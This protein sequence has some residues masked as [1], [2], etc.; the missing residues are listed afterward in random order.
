M[1]SNRIERDSE[2]DKSDY[3][4]MGPES[5]SSTSLSALY[6][7][8][9]RTRDSEIRSGIQVLERGMGN[10]LPSIKLEDSK[11]T[12]APKVEEPRVRIDEPKVEGP[13]QE[14]QKPFH[15]GRRALEV[16]FASPEVQK[17][18]DGNGSFT[19]EAIA[20]V[21]AEAAANGNNETRDLAAFVNRHFEPLSRMDDDDAITFDPVISAADIKQLPIYEEGIRGGYFYRRQDPRIGNKDLLEAAAYGATIGTAVQGVALA[22]GPGS[23][24]VGVVAAMPTTLF[25]AAGGFVGGSMLGEYIE[26]T[27]H[28]L[29]KYPLGLGGLFAGGA[30]GTGAAVYAWGPTLGGSLGYYVMSTHGTKMWERNERPGYETMFKEMRSLRY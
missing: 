17:H 11:K 9:F 25:G 16:F 24:A 10:A 1:P 5:D 15:N 27:R 30:A 3:R 18:K 19:R 26:G 13:K 7:E 28:A 2:N 14:E 29:L 22:L 20:R 23:Y 4:E 12:E 6:D 21:G 8:A